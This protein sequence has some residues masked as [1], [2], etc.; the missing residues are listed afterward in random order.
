ET[1]PK[2]CLL[3]EIEP[4]CRY[5][6]VCTTEAGLV[7][8]RMGDII[9]CTRFLTRADDLVPLPS[10]LH[11]IPRIPLISVA[12]RMGNLL[13]IIGE[14]T[15]EQNLIDTIAKTVDEWRQQG[16][17]ADIIDFTSY[18]KLDAFPPCYIFFFELGDDQLYETLQLTVDKLVDQYLRQFNFV[19]DRARDA[20]YIACAKCNFVRNGTFSTFI[21]EKLLTAHASPIQVKPHRLLKTEQHIQ[22]FH[23]N[24]LGQ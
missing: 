20:T 17:I 12:Y 14:K 5:E 23:A 1:Q 2:T 22:Y 19:Y 24:C 16:I 4:G 11:Q 9:E 10:E 3:S 13:D 6:L 8:Y 15:T 18:P 21:H 7:R